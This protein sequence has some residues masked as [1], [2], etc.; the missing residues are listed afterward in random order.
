TT[1]GKLDDTVAARQAA[2]K[3]TVVAV[4]IDVEERALAVGEA[5]AKPTFVAM[6]ARPQ[7]AA[8]SGLAG[9]ERARE[10]ATRAIG[11]GA[12]DQLVGLE[13]ADVPGAVDIRDGAFPV[14]LVVAELALHHVAVRRLNTPGA[15][16]PALDGRADHAVTVGEQRRA[17]A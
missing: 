8:A 15:L 4:A 12:L 13:P 16:Q 6:A 17:D 9:L 14:Q 3:R 2:G 5:L 7:V 1:V 11:D 10:H